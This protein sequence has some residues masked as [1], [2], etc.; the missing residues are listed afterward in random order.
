MK[1]FLFIVGVVLLFVVLAKA[2]PSNKDLCMMG[3]VVMSCDRTPDGVEIKIVDRD[4][5]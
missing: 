2:A 3:K 5:P 4:D 1:F